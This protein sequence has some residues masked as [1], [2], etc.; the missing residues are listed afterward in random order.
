MSE[1]DVIRVRVDSGRAVRDFLSLLEQQAAEGET[2]APAKPR[3][4]AIYRELAPYRLVEYAYVDEG[5]GEVEGAYIGLP[6]GSIFSVGDEIPEEA[7]DAMVVGEVET[8]A[9]V[10][11]YVIL[12]RP[13][14]SPLI[15]DFLAKLA[16]HVDL[17]LVG[18]FQGKDSGTLIARAHPDDNPKAAA[19]L[20]ETERHLT[21]AQV[22]DRFVACSEASDGRAFARIS[23]A[24]TKHVVEFSSARERDEFVAWSRRLCERSDEVLRPA[25][26]TLL[27]A[28]GVV[29]THLEGLPALP[30]DTGEAIA[31]WRRIKDM[32]DA[33]EAGASMVDGWMVREA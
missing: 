1:D 30:A 27:P 32:V 29:V 9:P 22:L 25:E 12:A 18:I 28:D 10:Y 6:D 17:P 26:P 2:R 21:K 11:V 5:V 16:D 24:F 19:A 31:Y 14:S 8:L 13:V 4:T 20:A 3:A 33:T 15:D 23:Y 7:V